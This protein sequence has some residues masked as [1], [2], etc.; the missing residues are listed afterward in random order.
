MATQRIP[1][2]PL[3]VVLFPGGTLPLHIF[4]PRYKL[5]IRSSIDNSSPFGMVLARENGIARVGCTA[6]VAE[7]VKAYE[8]GRMDIEA[9][10]QTPYRIL[11]VHQDN[12]LL[13]ATVELLEDDFQPGPQDV[14]TE[15][16]ALYGK[17]HTEL[18]DAPAPPL[19]A[20]PLAYQIAG[21]LPLDNGALQELL[22]LRSEAAR[23]AKLAEHLRR[24]L[25]Q[26]AQI[27]RRQLKAAGNGHG[28]A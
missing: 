28:L 8:D 2:F 27:R 18:H 16:C 20:T 6:E 19:D 7:V 23:R 26:L 1:L 12:P 14:S 11:E 17:C 22:E 9:L 15:L 5:M 10:G 25:P 4:E 13:E 3:D 21:R 24:F